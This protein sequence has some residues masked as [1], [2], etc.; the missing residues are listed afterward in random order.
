MEN[1]RDE[2]I[3][4]QNWNATAKD[5]DR[6]TVVST[7]ANDTKDKKTS[8]WGNSSPKSIV[9]DEENWDDEGERKNNGGKS[10]IAPKNV[11]LSQNE[12]IHDLEP[13]NDDS[14]V[15]FDETAHTTIEK[16]V[17]NEISAKSIVTSTAEDNQPPL[18]T[19]QQPAVVEENPTQ[20]FD[21]FDDNET[22]TITPE[23]TAFSNCDDK[24]PVNADNFDDTTESNTTPLYDEPIEKIKRGVPDEQ[25]DNCT[26]EPTDEKTWEPELPEVPDINE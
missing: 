20:S 25:N 9:S 2:T 5:E 13:I 4:R 23:E 8:R 12:P 21:M 11:P 10:A 26:I 16:S 24:S 18:V 14:D 3:N 17:Q 6:A 7:E 19:L 22:T 1:R 15:D